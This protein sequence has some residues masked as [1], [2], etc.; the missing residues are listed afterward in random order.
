MILRLFAIVDSVTNSAKPAQIRAA[1]SDVLATNKHAIR[2]IP[3]F[4][5][6][7][8]PVIE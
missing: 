6:V 4:N 3:I 7:L 5:G 2:N 8:T 1:V